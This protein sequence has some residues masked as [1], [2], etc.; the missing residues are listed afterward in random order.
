MP[1]EPPQP[2]KNWI[3]PENGAAIVPRCRIAVVNISNTNMNP[4][5]IVSIMAHS[6]A[7]RPGIDYKPWVNVGPP[8]NASLV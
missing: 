2:V 8:N 3:Y 6:V 5:M 7:G 1:G 4:Y